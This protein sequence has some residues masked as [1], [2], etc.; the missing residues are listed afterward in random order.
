MPVIKYSIRNLEDLFEIEKER[1]KI[2]LASHS[3]LTF[4]TAEL[5]IYL[6]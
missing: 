6:I 4:L 3:E 1:E 2:C 5:E